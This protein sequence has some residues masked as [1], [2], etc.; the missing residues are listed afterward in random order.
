MADSR[1]R[2]GARLHQ[3]DLECFQRYRGL[4]EDANILLDGDHPVLKKIG[5]DMLFWAQLRL[6][7][8][9]LHDLRKAPLFGSFITRIVEYIRG[10]EFMH[11]ALL[12]DARPFPNAARSCSLADLGAAKRTEALTLLDRI[13]GDLQIV[14]SQ[15]LR[16]HMALKKRL[17]DPPHARFAAP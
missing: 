7:L 16:A 11:K 17:F 4:V 12:D 13:E 1:R 14:Y 6:K 8:D 3:N 2:P 9:A 15:V 10:S 5:E